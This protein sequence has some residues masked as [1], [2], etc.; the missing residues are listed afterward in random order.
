[1]CR[2]CILPLQF[3]STSVF[4]HCLILELARVF[5]NGRPRPVIIE[6]MEKRIERGDIKQEKLDAIQVRVI[7]QAVLSEP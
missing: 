1:M 6:D 3:A 7:E 2:F 5:V 4:F